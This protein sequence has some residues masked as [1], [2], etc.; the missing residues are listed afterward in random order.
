MAWTT[1]LTAVANA[2]LTA[3]QW[4]ATVRDNL[5]ETAA[6][7][8]S[9]LGS[10]FTTTGVNSLGE[11]L[12]ANAA[13]FTAETTTSTSYTSLATAGPSA[14][15]TASGFILIFISASAANNTVNATSS[16]G[17][18]VS[19]ATTGTPGDSAALRVTS[20]TA[21]AQVAASYVLYRIVTA[22][23]NTVTCDYA[24]TSGTGTFSNR[25]ITVF[26][27]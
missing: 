15:V 18:D 19:G 11:R 12:P 14:T 22:G 4:N 26:P 24:V 8:A 5:L 16:V 2:A 13:V 9:T 7:K 25:R 20:S 1:P 23:S 6:A 3:A 21:N 27:Y 17:H 10:Y